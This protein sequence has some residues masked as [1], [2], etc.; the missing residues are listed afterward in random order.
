[1]IVR[2]HSDELVGRIVDDEDVDISRA[3]EEH[4]VSTLAGIRDELVRSRAPEGVLEDLA[5]RLVLVNKYDLQRL[6]ALDSDE[7]PAPGDR[8]MQERTLLKFLGKAGMDT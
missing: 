4:S 2:S 5:R 7:W 6:A 8:E 1:M 3:R